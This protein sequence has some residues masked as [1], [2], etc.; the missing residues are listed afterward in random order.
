M[1]DYVYALDGTL[2]VAATCDASVDAICVCQVL[3][4]GIFAMDLWREIVEYANVVTGDDGLFRQV[5]A[6]ETGAARYQNSAVLLHGSF[7]IFN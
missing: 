5:R 4:M 3:K 7:L 6:N 2:E 1:D